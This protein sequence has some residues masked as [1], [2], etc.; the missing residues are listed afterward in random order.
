MTAKHDGMKNIGKAIAALV[1]GHL[2]DPH[3]VLGMHAAKDGGMVVRAY[4]PDADA[5]SVLDEAGG[6]T[7]MRKTHPAGLFQA[8]FTERKTHFKYRLKW[9]FGQQ[10][11]IADDPYRF[12][13]GLGEVDTHL[14]NEG[15]HR[16]IYDVMGCRHTKMDGVEGALFAVWAPNAAR[17]SVVGD[18][19]RWDGRRHQMRLMGSSGIWEIFIPGLESGDV[20][21]YEI[22]AANGDIFLKLDPYARRIELRPNNAAVVPDSTPHPWTDGD[23]MT[24]RNGTNWLERP[25]NIYEVHLGSWRRPELAP[26]ADPDDNFY[27]YRELAVQ[28][29]DY[30]GRMGYT[31]IE[32]LPITEHPLDISWGYQVSGYYAPTARFG[33]P[34]DFAFF[35]NHLHENN[36]GVILDWV[37]AHFPK[38]AFSLGR[39]DGTALYE[40]EDPRQ[41]EQRDWG[42][43]IFNL[44]RREVKNFLLGS[45]LYWMEEFHID[46]FRVDAVASMIYLDF[47]REDGDWIPN[48]YGGRENLDAIAFL[49][50]FNEL[51]HELH[52]GIVNIAEEST[53]W[54]GVSRPTYAGG[55]G[56]TF[57]WDMGWMHDT[58]DYFERE[59][60][61][62]KF[63]HNQLSFSMMYAYSENFVLPLS[64]DEVVHGKKSL[65]DKMPGDLWQMF[66]NLRA[67]TAYMISHPGK[68]LLFMGC[69]FGQFIE[70][71]CKQELDWFLIDKYPTH[72]GVAKLNQDLNRLYLRAPALWELDHHHRGFE[73]IDANDSEQS[74]FSYLRWDKARLAPVVVILNLTPV[75]RHYYRIGVPMHGKWMVLI[76]TDHEVYGGSN[77]GDSGTV[78]SQHCPWHGFPQSV[79]LTLPPL[80][81]LMLA[82][83]NTI[84]E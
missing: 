12:L 15:E 38:D 61:H 73:W 17:V 44:G 33:T 16:R 29:A 53:S 3:S 37:P 62:R 78:E 24:R 69:E 40:H 46:G 70:W 65:L 5:I 81:V 36:I 74:V 34:A 55:L 54:A 68:K 60:V 35:V 57:K 25:M 6:V 39:F 43:Y 31:H 27:N 20:Y 1:G 51:T 48:Q 75:V 32:L 28:L 50:R 23:W 49:K 18:F 84:P 66:A 26:G 58:L 13:P 11:F 71:N 45:A 77:A 83:K 67:M 82:V 8:Q 76:N 14:F 19:N 41:G 52:P 47:S 7:V 22:R 64:H 4:A 79:E 21:K 9:R 30:A 80:G 72:R 63:H 2:S 42:T 59:P 10:D 56:F